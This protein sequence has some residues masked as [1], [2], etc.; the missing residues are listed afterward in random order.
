[1]ITAFNAFTPVVSHPSRASKLHVGVTSFVDRPRRA[2]VQRGH[3]AAQHF[4]PVMKIGILYST[5]TGNTEEVATL[6]KQFLGDRADDPKDI[7]DVEASAITGYEALVVGAPTWNT[8]ADSERTGTDWDEFLYGELESLDLS[9][10]A[11]AVYGVGDAIGYGDNFCD[12]IEEMHDGFQKKGAKMIGYTAPPE[13]YE[14]SESKSV[15]DGKFLG[16]PVDH[17]NFSDLTEDRVKSWC[18][19]VEQEAGV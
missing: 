16:L 2:N 11:V 19:Q 14:F 10:K 15:R 7:S 12:A 8:D 4:S 17:V 9:G 1:M 13:E 18:I 5:V 6:C 3:R